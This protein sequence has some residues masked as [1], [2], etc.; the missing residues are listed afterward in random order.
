[1]LF[2]MSSV[3]SAPSK[4]SSQIQQ[5]PG[6]ARGGLNDNGE[7]SQILPGGLR[8]QN[9]NGVNGLLSSSASQHQSTSMGHGLDQMPGY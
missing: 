3:P 2:D 8:L 5:Q 9:D 6:G 4:D 7:A 1:M